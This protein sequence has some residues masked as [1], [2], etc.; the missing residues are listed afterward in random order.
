MKGLG[1]VSTTT[2]NTNTGS[3]TDLINTDFVPADVDAGNWDVLKPYFKALRDRVINSVGDLE[4]WLLDRSELEASI[5]EAG[6]NRYIAM[7]CNTE[8]K[9]IEQAFLEFVENIEPKVKPEGFALDQ[10]YVACPFRKELDQDRYQV[11]D[12]D[13]EAEVKLY[14]DENVALETELAKLDQQYNK[15][16]GAMTVEFDGEEKTMPQMATFLQKTDRAVRQSAWEGIAERRAADVEKIN[17][18][19]DKMV[20]IRHTIAQN[21]G[22][23]NYRD[24][25]FEKMHRFD[26]TPADCEA[27]HQACE[28]LV[29]PLQRKINAERKMQLDVES[30]RPWDLAVD[31]KGRD[32]L[33]PFDGADELV[34]GSERIFQ[35]VDARLGNMFARLRE[36]GCLDL[37]SRKG[38]APGGYQYSRDRSRQPFIF[39]NAAGM[40]RDVETMLH[41]G[42]HAFHSILSETEPLLHYR[43]APMEFA[44]VASMSMELTAH[45]FLTEFY[46]D[47]EA[48]RAVR[49]HL[50]GVVNTLPWIA[51]ID[52]FQHWLY[53]HPDHTRSEREAHW[54]SLLDRFGPA[55]DHEGYEQHR[56]NAWHRQLHLF[57]VPFYYIEYGI[58][59]LGALQLW[60]QYKQDTGKAIQNY[61]DALALG[62]SKP[63]PQLF[64]AAGMKFD[65]GP[66]AVKSLI[67]EVE[68]ELNTLPA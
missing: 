35:K 56:P 34:D 62:G 30:L 21:A 29:V 42:G 3:Q 26:Y 36:P 19:F 10:K 48:Q 68:N 37:D 6:A 1:F 28:E 49:E 4:Q 16:C 53:T 60:L 63:L 27:F 15:I 38:K 51:T 47:D 22:F 5:S 57:G 11:I 14:R 20:K 39:M 44:E 13:T 7:T 32:P 66:N 8:D 23:D 2:S 64:E 59:Q 50:E 24:Y 45:P 46:S 65:F 31:V 33:T 55:I 52:A 9:E 41:E 43:H 67:A 25:M 40:Q 61:C 58:A 54:L 12:R 17:D 18:I